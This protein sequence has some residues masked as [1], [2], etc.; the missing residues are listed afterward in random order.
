LSADDLAAR[1][2]LYD[3]ADE[4]GIVSDRLRSAMA[5]DPARATR[6]LE[7]ALRAPG[8]R[9]RPAFAI[10]RWRSRATR[11]EARRTALNPSLSDGIRVDGVEAPTLEALE[12]LWAL[13]PS[14]GVELTLRLMSATIARGGGLAELRPGTDA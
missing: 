10:A 3:L 1:A 13:P 7:H 14:V 4:L 6:I 9:N 5:D 2:R 12:R 8:I 11:S